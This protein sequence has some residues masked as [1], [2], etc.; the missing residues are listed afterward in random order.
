MKKYKINTPLTILASITIIFSCKSQNMDSILTNFI[1]NEATHKIDNRMYSRELSLKETAFLKQ[2]FD[3]FINKIK[4]NW[5]VYNEEQCDRA[6]DILTEIT[7]KDTINKM[8]RIKVV[9][10]YST[11]LTSD[12]LGVRAAVLMP[13]TL[14]ELTDYNKTAKNNIEELFTS[15][16]EQYLRFE[17]YKLAGFLQIEKAEK[18]LI[19]RF[20]NKNEKK[21]KWYAMLCLAR[22]GNKRALDFCLEKL[23]NDISKQG[24]FGYPSDVEKIAYYIRQP[25]SLDLLIEMFNN[26]TLVRDIS[27]PSIKGHIGYRSLGYIEKSITMKIPKKITNS[28]DNSVD[29]KTYLERTKIVRKWLK[30]SRNK[31]VLNINV[32]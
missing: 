8:N 11:L 14:Y 12:T 2:N 1:T 21:H 7:Y 13:L 22:M 6:L 3:D 10:F 16:N 23:K 15:D 4:N 24:K 17:L 29:E 27:K 30:E 31:F 18:Y 32:Y 26:P 20:F 25:E 9:E 5:S 28:I 19:E